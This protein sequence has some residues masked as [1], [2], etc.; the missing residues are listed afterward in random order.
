CAPRR[1]RRLHA[2]AEERK[3]RF[4]DDRGRHA[5]RRLNHDRRG[6][7]RQ[8]VAGEYAAARYAERE[9]R[10]Y[11]LALLEREHFAT[12]QASVARPADR[13]QSDDDVAKAGAQDRAHRDREQ[14]ARERE[15]N[16]HDTHRPEVDRTA[17]VA[18]DRAH[19]HADRGGDDDGRDAYLKRYARAVDDATELIASELVLPERMLER[20]A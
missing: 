14:D 6:E 13:A 10:L 18:G 17:G 19:E 4:R 1:G 7:Q 3:A 8:D 9:C 15:E 20:R 12:N 5:E 16:V 11:V 2:E